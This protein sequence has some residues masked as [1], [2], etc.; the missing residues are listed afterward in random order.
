MTTVKNAPMPMTTPY[1]TPCERM[2]ATSVEAM[3]KSAL[4]RVSLWEARSIEEQE[5]S[6][7]KRRYVKKVLADLHEGTLSPGLP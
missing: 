1:P 5:I 4:Q 7:T 3:L 6:K 2:G